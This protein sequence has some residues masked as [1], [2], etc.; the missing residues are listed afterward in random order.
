MIVSAFLSPCEID[1]AALRNS[2]V[3]VVDVLRATST[4]ATALH[5]GAVRI[6]P[7]ASA[8]RAREQARQVNDLPVLLGGEK[9]GF[10]IEGFDLGNS[11]LDYSPEKVKGQAI[12]F[13]TTNGT[14][15]FLRVKSASKILFGSFLNAKALSRF[16]NTHRPEHLIFA[17]SGLKGHFSL[18]DSVCSGYIIN[19]LITPERE[20]DG[21]TACAALAQRFSDDTRQLLFERSKHG[22]YLKNNGFTADLEYCSRKDFLNIIPVF[23]EKQNGIVRFG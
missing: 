8:S 15:T 17:N 12:I 23:D 20:N 13:K 2:W 18:E 14:E 10:R 16:I 4:I 1:Q 19:Q 6:Q 21:A 3:V 9:D 22:R 5:N 11:P 7:V